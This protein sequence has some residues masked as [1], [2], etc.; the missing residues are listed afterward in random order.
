MIII[1]ITAVVTDYALH[2]LENGTRSFFSDILGIICASVCTYMKI[3]A[4]NSIHFLCHNEIRCTRL[5]CSTLR[6][7][8][9]LC[10]FHSFTDVHHQAG[11]LVAQLVK[12]HSASWGTR[13]FIAVFRSDRMKNCPY[14]RVLFLSDPLVSYPPSGRIL[15]EWIWE[16]NCIVVVVSEWTSRSLMCEA[17]GNII[18]QTV[19]KTLG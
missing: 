1:I 13:R 18:S 2:L 11:F 16:R 7:A 17:S 4:I 10:R 5:F 8:A 19:D 14:L 3:W 15:L 12:K 6:A 9:D